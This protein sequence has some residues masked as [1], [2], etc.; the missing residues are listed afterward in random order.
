MG[1]MAELAH[2]VEIAKSIEEANMRYSMNDRLPDLPIDPPEPL[3]PLSDAE[4]NMIEEALADRAEKEFQTLT[5]EAMDWLCDTQD[6]CDLAPIIVGHLHGEHKD[7][8]WNAR[9]GAEQLLH[10]YIQYRQATADQR[11]RDELEQELIPGED[12]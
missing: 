3:H 12:D 9:K 6:I 10:D 8:Y 2:M 1:R 4:Q 5:P 7:A 11:E